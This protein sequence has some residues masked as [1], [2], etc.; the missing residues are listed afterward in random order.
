MFATVAA[1]IYSLDRLPHIVFWIWLHL[2]QFNVSNQTFSVDEDRLNK[3]DRP[4]PAGRITLSQAWVLR[5]ALVPLCFAL[6]LSYSAR[7]LYA[8]AT[9]ITLT[10]IYNEL[11]VHASH[12]I[13]RNVMNA[14]G[15]ASMEAG[16]TL[17]AGTVLLPIDGYFTYA[18]V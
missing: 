1:P 2:L 5:W 7:V 14:L 13:V 6:S 15:F 16:A 11:H 3:A 9:F 4:L 18:A 10:C 17:V 8:S 12:G